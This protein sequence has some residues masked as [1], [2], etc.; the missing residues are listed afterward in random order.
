M[1]KKTAFILI[2]FSLVSS[3]AAAYNFKQD[4]AKLDES[5][6]SSV[7]I[8]TAPK[9]TQSK[10]IPKIK[11]KPSQYASIGSTT[12]TPIK[13]YKDTPKESSKDAATKS[14]VS[15]HTV[16]APK[17]GMKSSHSNT[18]ARLVSS[19]ITRSKLRPAVGL[20]R[21]VIGYYAEDWVGDTGSLNSV[22]NYGGKMAGI[23]TFSFRL[24]SDG[25]LHGTTPSAAV[26]KAHASGGTALALIHNY[27]DGQF[28]RN[29]VHNILAN[30]AVRSKTIG[31]ILSVVKKGGF[32]GV[33]IDFENIGPKDRKLFNEFIK[34]L[35]QVFHKN[36]YQVTISV[37]AKT[38]DAA[39]GWGGA[40]DYKFL[41]GTVDRVMLMTY[42]EH[43]FG[44]SPGPVASIGWV[45]QVT[46]YA[47]SQIPADKVLL[48][49]GVYGYEWE[50]GAGRSVRSLPASTALKV[51]SQF[52]AKIKW[53]NSAQV[54]YFYYWPKGVKRV[55]WFESNN[56]A[57]FKMNLVNKYDLAGV[58][59]W[60]LGFEDKGF[61]NTV[62]QKFGVRE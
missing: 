35:T 3:V 45:E 44:G 56:S 55:V 28:N 13:S 39:T 19:T 16:S 9:N 29:V 31:N 33:N 43:W 54:P 38:Y 22:K 37:P 50:P 24:H 42:D 10:S 62:I 20:N 36:G 53:D 34:E 5:E 18:K 11:E 21:E 57:A 30:P 40:F 6:K 2:F 4:F 61:W 7:V 27:V 47:V 58:A 60:R 59:V 1:S 49:L 52:G 15:S 26:K 12:D 23:A 17:T 8:A 51:A 25:T 48:G 14:S 46:R 41:G 32:D